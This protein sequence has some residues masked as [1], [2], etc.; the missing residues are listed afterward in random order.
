MKG[1]VGGYEDA[2]MDEESRKTEFICKLGWTAES[3]SGRREFPIFQWFQKSAPVLFRIII[4]MVQRLQFCSKEGIK[5]TDL[6]TC[7]QMLS[8]LP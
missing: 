2:V 5:M 1:Y 3:D 4:S 8:E 6:S 7:R